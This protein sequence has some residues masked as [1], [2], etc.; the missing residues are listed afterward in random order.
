[1]KLKLDTHPNVQFH[2]EACQYETHLFVEQYKQNNLLKSPCFLIIIALPH[3]ERVGT[4]RNLCCRHT[5]VSRVIPPTTCE[6]ALCGIYTPG[7]WY[8][9][10]C[11]YSVVYSPTNYLD[12]LCMSFRCMLRIIS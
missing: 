8:I 5:I 7:V 1:M 6:H 2:N 11:F 12:L 4:T 10:G 3:D 9:H